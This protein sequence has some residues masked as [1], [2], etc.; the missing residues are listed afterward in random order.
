MGKNADLPLR[1]NLKALK[2]KGLR[3]DESIL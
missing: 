2:F 3:P 1:E